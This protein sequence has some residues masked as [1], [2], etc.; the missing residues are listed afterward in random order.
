MN[1]ALSIR[2]FH[3]SLEQL[4]EVSQ[5]GGVLPRTR[6]IDVATFYLER[7]DL[8]R[9]KSTLVRF[10]NYSQYYYL[11]KEAISDY[12]INEPPGK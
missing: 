4:G 12:L 7:S 1:N 8:F 3:K 11:L 2:E 6:S 9:N 5:G 10:A